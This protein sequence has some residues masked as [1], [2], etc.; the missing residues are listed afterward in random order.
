MIPWKNIIRIG[1]DVILV[2]VPSTFERR[3]LAI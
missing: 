3:S 2:E 1:S